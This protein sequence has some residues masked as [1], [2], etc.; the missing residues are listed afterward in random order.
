LTRAS[1]PVNDQHRKDKKVGFFMT[2]IL[3]IVFD[4]IPSRPF[5]EHPIA[6]SDL[7]SKQKQGYKN[8]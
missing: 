3:D 4:F 7:P 2:A 8:E 5:L 1:H 6:A